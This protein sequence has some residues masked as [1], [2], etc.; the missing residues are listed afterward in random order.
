MAGDGHHWYLLRV[1]N[2]GRQAQAGASDR[3]I[4][5][6][7][8]AGGQPACAQIGCRSW[9]PWV[10]AGDRSFP[11]VLARKWHGACRST[12]EDAADGIVDFVSSKAARLR[13][14]RAAWRSG[15]ACIVLRLRS[16]AFPPGW[17]STGSQVQAA[18]MSALRM[19]S[20]DGG[21]LTCP[22]CGVAVTTTTGFRQPGTNMAKRHSRLRSSKK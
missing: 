7:F 13:R 10:T 1:L 21:S 8:Q 17:V 15:P 16:H 14:R 6:S 22:S 4:R 5:R 3:L 11:L 20:R 18:F 19:T 9:C 12:V 2:G